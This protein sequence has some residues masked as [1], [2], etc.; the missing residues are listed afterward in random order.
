MPRITLKQLVS[1]ALSAKNKRVSGILV[2]ARVANQF[3]EL[4]LLKEENGRWLFTKMGT[5]RANVEKV[6]AEFKRMVAE[7]HAYPRVDVMIDPLSERVTGVVI[8]G[9]VDMDQVVELAKTAE[10][11]TDDVLI[12]VENARIVNR[13]SRF[14]IILNLGVSELRFAAFEGGI[15][16]ITKALLLHFGNNP[17][18]RVEGLLIGELRRMPSDGES[19]ETVLASDPRSLSVRYFIVTG[20]E[21]QPAELAAEQAA[22]GEEPE[23]GSGG[24]AGA[25]DAE[26]SGE[27]SRME[28][29][30]LAQGQRMLER[31][32]EG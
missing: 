32:L 28:A 8:T 12:P 3:V 22:G 15:G 9:K 16:I 4:L 7:D 1:A 5:G 11:E 24:E 25:G 19:I 26:G 2:D 27:A 18:M 13:G 31:L 23:S 21:E 6:L 14:D 17:D 29:E 20:V 30:L 10:L